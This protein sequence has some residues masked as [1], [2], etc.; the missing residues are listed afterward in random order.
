MK[1][2]SST[3]PQ[4]LISSSETQEALGEKK[5]KALKTNIFLKTHVIAKPA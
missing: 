5:K 3:G 4:S 1:W 2:T